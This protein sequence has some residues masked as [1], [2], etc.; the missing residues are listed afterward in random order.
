MPVYLPPP[1][2]II[3][4]PPA[5]VRIAPERHGASDEAA[6]L[7]AIGARAEATRPAA[8]VAR[9]AF[10]E[11][12]ERNAIDLRVVGRSGLEPPV[13]SAIRTADE[14]R[15]AQI[16]GRG[17]ADS[18]FS[19]LDRWDRD[20]NPDSLRL[21]AGGTTLA[22]GRIVD[23]LAS[24]SREVRP[25]PAPAQSSAVNETLRTWY[26]DP[27]NYDRVLAAIG[28]RT[29]MCANFVTTALEK[30]GALNIP[31]GTSYPGYDDDGAPKSVRM[32]APSLARYLENVKGWQRV[33]GF[34]NM[35][36]GDLLFTN[37][38]EGTYNHVMMLHSWANQ[39]SGLARVIDNQG[40][41]H[42]RSLSGASG[43]SP[44]SYAVRAP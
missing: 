44:V 2:A 29:N 30:S 5:E 13:L 4:E 36:P 32:W 37:G 11:R 16:F 9:D 42:L 19:R 28:S 24:A 31:R 17:E 27:S 25:A 33:Y 23:V 38:A 15:D 14:N 26:S 35:K 21:R 7:A 10:V 1:L 41:T 43:Q 6:I 22:M 12:H 34:S 3:P 8:S 18:L 20:G 40:F 39:S